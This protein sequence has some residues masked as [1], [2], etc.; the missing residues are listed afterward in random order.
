MDL[1]SDKLTIVLHAVVTRSLLL[2]GSFNSTDLRERGGLQLPVGRRSGLQVRLVEINMLCTLQCDS[3]N[4][5]TPRDRETNSIGSGAS[6]FHYSSD[7]TVCTVV[8]ETRH[9]T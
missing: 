9:R 2:P 1:R 6:V 4:L 5:P 8:A 7:L 3:S